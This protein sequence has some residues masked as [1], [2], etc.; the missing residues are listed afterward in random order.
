MDIRKATTT[1]TGSATNTLVLVNLLDIALKV[2]HLSQDGR[3]PEKAGASIKNEFKHFTADPARE[4]KLGSTPIK[5]LM[6]PP[7]NFLAELV[8]KTITGHLCGHN[9]VTEFK[10]RAMSAMCDLPNVIAY[11]WSNFFNHQLTEGAKEIKL[12]EEAGF[13][14]ISGKLKYAGCIS[15]AL[16]TLFPNRAW[17]ETGM[18]TRSNQIFRSIPTKIALSSMR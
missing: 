4:W 5:T 6:R 17:E 9:A 14:T 1:I 7:F 11:D 8:T 3:S 16:E 15:Y 2:F 10:V 12:G 18:C 13:Y